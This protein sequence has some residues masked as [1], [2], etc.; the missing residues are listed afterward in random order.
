MATATEAVP[1]AQIAQALVEFSVNGEF[2]EENVSSLTIDAAA[3]P[4]AIKALANA[5]AA[6]QAEIHAINEE[7]ANDVRAW[8]KNAQSVQDDMLRSKALAN[9]IIKT[10]E[11]PAVSGKALREAE[12]KAQFLVRE[13]SYNSQVQE[14]LRGIKTV[15]STLDQV[16]KARDERKIL[17][18]L[19]LLE[20]S[21]KELDA[22]PVSRSCRAVKLLDIRAFELKSD[23]HDVFD[24]V[25][26]LLVHVDVENQKVSISGSREDE[27]MTLANAVIGL[28]AYREVDQRMEQLW[29]DINNAI[30]I[31][32]MGVTRD[33]LPGIHVQDNILELQGST[34][35]SVKSLFADLEKVFAYLVQRLPAGLV[36]TISSTL[37]PEVIHRIT[38][39]WLDSAVPSS[40]KDM[41]RFQDTISLAKAF[42]GT[43]KSLGFSNFGDL[44]EWTENA[45][46]VWLS[47]CREAALDTVR[48]KLSNGLGNTTRAEKIEKQMV[49]KSE[50]QQLT[51]NGAA[52]ADDDDHGWGAWDDGEEAA[53]TKD[54]TEKPP[55]DGEDDGADAWGWG[56]EAA[57]EEHLKEQTMKSSKEDDEEDDAAEAWGW[58]DDGNNK[59]SETKKEPKKSATETRELTLKE[60]YSISSNPQ[61]ILDLISVIA[62]DGAA[63]TEDSYSSSPVATAAAGLFGLPTLVL[64]M[65]RAV[66][67]YFYSPQ[68]GGNMYLYNDANWLA[69]KLT[70][71]ASTWK[72]RDNI[73]KRAQNMLRLDN[74]V[75]SLKAFAN[76]AYTNEI[77][78]HKTI[79]R[80]RLGGEQNLFQQDDAE[81][82]VSAAIAHLRSMAI[83]W[84]SIVSRSV[85]QQA[86]GSLIDAVASKIIVDVMELP[87]I[88]QDEA[89]NIAKQI[90]SVEE[91]DDLFL[92]PGSKVPSTAQFASLWLRLK[93]LSEVLQSNLRDVRYLWAEGELSLYFTVDEVIDLINASFEDN[94]RTREVVKEIRGNP[95]PRAG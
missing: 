46:R 12:A 86:V 61:S 4:E 95:Q 39:V 62:E 73:S 31:P 45:P 43:L 51:A 53:D 79:L 82:C 38:C 18:A 60:T 28:Q 74:D 37:L 80:D 76:R 63:L 72:T 24:R 91:L 89:Y 65:L 32:R 69:E 13:L 25:W 17:D 55:E 70:E 10:S 9:E 41:E 83:T 64:A 48:T 6:L 81:A 5:K 29:K 30:L 8:Q 92:T 44:Q 87:S 15:N 75:K 22:I 26:R 16:E 77:G 35:K 67:P 71:F 11:A 19:H 78:V 14:A 36:E 93:Y 23:V 20:K 56:D 49:S 68:P 50:G 47:K 57:E 27:P 42:C 59:D 34:D 52:A 3:L 54:A 84:E 7:T 33:T 21:W 94:P 1:T 90:A 85:W 66:S 58:G 2:P 88:G 40:L